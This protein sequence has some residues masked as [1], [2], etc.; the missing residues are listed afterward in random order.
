MP[1]I[2]GTVLP[3]LQ[4]A[5]TEAVRFSAALLNDS[6]E[7]FWAGEHWFMEVHDE[8]DLPLFTLTFSASNGSPRRASRKLGSDV[9][10]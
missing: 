1:D 7:E 6:A 8:F 4:A 2:E 5:R 9:G 10:G 3:D